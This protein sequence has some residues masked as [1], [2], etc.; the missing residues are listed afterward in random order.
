MGGSRQ[1]GAALRDVQAKCGGWDEMNEAQS[2]STVPSTLQVWHRCSCA[3]RLP[4][5]SLLRPLCKQALFC[6][7]AACRHTAGRLPSACMHRRRRCHAG[8]RSSPACRWGVVARGSSTWCGAPCSW[9]HRGCWR[10]RPHAVVV[11][12]TLLR[13]PCSPSMVMPHPC[14]PSSSTRG[15]PPR[16]CRGWKRCGRR[17]RRAVQGQRSMGSGTMSGRLGRHRA[18]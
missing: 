14:R 3:L 16:C 1:T 12:P 11:D 15:C 8:W 7:P 4:L 17:G 2:G 10:W 5:F 9:G 18:T 6:P 13:L